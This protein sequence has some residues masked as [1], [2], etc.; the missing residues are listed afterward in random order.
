MNA[1]KS[2]LN[3]PSAVGYFRT[4]SIDYPQKP[5]HE[6]VS[7]H[8]VSYCQSEAL[9]WLPA[10]PSD[11]Q[12]LIPSVLARNHIEYAEDQA[13]TDPEEEERDLLYELM[14]GDGQN[15]DD[16]K[17]SLS[18]ILR[19]CI[20]GEMANARVALKQRQQGRGA[21]GFAAQRRNSKAQNTAF[22]L[23]KNYT[24][25]QGATARA[26]DDSGKLV[27][28]DA[29]GNEVEQLD[30]E[31]QEEQRKKELAEMKA[32]VVKLQEK[33]KKMDIEIEK[34]EASYKKK[35]E[36]LEEES[37]RSEQL[38]REAMTKK[39]TIDLIPNAQENL[40]KLSK[41]VESSQQRFD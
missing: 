21:E 33:L 2:N 19:G 10:Q 36:E 14:G 17:Q 34:Q 23:Q 13:K 37:K 35:Q 16:E 6:A 3:R 20:S 12:W 25:S 28:V 7:K 32:A 40:I 15:D 22:S 5:I 30:D 26:V 38:Q 39:K 41:I 18:Q 29:T 11:Y 31:E 9:E 24:Q 27:T 8:R 1:K 4:C